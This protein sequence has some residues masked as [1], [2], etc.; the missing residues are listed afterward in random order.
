MG[1]VVV[2]VSMK[3]VA[4]TSIVGFLSMSGA[5]AMGRRALY[6]DCKTEQMMFRT[7]ETQFASVVSML[8]SKSL[9]VREMACKIGR[10]RIHAA[11]LLN[12]V[13]R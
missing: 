5:S 3:A 9:N 12:A 8:K 4:V 13:S 6:E 11:A 7:D 10:L 2:I 1:N